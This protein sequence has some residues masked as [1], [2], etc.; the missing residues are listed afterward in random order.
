MSVWRLRTNSGG[1]AI[2]LT[3]GSS[4]VGTTHVP[5]LA[6]QFGRLVDAE[7]AARYLG[8]LAG[9]GA[10]NCPMPEEVND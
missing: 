5:S 7:D 2:W 9:Y 8:N 4:G 1:S 3:I 6:V 10:V